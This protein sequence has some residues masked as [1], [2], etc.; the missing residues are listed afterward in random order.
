[1]TSSLHHSLVL[2]VL[3]R[4]STDRLQ[5]A[6][7][8]LADG[9]LHI[10]LT[11]ATE[12]EIRALVKNGAGQEYGCTLTE[13]L[14]TCSCKDALYRATV[15]KHVTALAL[16]LLRMSQA[17]QPPQQVIHLAL[18]EGIALCGVLHPAR[19]WRWPYWPKLHWTETCTQCEAI[20]TQPVFTKTLA[21]VA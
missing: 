1:M 2:N 21:A 12:S 17:E 20:R 15:C 16:H 13:A 8:A 11:R 19:F 14:T 10:T 5:R 9:S 18:S 4:V 3:Q 6:V 7:N